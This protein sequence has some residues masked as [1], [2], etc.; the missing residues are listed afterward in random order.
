[1]LADHRFQDFQIPREIPADAI[2]KLGCAIIDGPRYK[3]SPPGDL[4]TP[5]GARHVESACNQ[6]PGLIGAWVG[7]CEA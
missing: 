3:V 1:M 2:C 5:Y 6:H 4:E 7:Y